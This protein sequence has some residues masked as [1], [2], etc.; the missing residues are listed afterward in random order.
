V[1]QWENITPLL[2]VGTGWAYSNFYPY[3]ANAQPGSYEFRAFIDTGDGFK[4]LATTTFTVSGTMVPYVYHHTSF[5]TTWNYGTST[6]Y[7]NL[8]PVDAKTV[9][10]PGDK[11]YFLSQAR[12]VYVTHQWRGELYRNNALLWSNTSNSLDVGSGWTF[13]NFY[14]FLDNAQPGSYQY[15]VYINVG[16]GFI[17]LDTKTFSV[18]GQI[19]DYKY[20]GATVAHGWQ[21]GQGND[22]WNITPVNA[23]TTYGVGDTVY[24]LAQ[25][26]NVY[27]DHRWKIDVARNGVALWTYSTDWN[28]VGS[29]WAYSNFNPANS[30]S[31]AGNYEAKIYFDPGT[32]FILV[33]TKN[34]NVI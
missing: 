29:G 17:L 23:T 25:A 32:G 27:V 13:S 8:Q 9:F 16:N 15:K 28:R 11:I 20:F 18:T 31:A 6:D 26:R 30:N 22:F 1:K 10:A 21:N 14:P 4:S 2:D 7:W 19:T 33:D 5:A 3:L 34:F 12:N 24:V